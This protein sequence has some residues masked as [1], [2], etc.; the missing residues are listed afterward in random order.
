VDFRPEIRDLGLWVKNQG[1]RPSCAI[2]ALLSALEYQAAK[3]DGTARRFDED[4][5]LRQVEE[6]TGRRALHGATGEDA[7]YNLVEVVDTIRKHGLRALGE[8][9]SSS[10]TEPAESFPFK[11]DFGVI[12]ATRTHQEI[13]LLVE[14]INRGF[15]LPIALSWP[16]PAATQGGLIDTQDP[17]PNYRHAVTLVGYENPTGKIEDTVF[18]FKNSWGVHWGASGFGRVSYRYFVENFAYAIIIQLSPSRQE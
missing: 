1:T 4:I 16:Y 7:G 11:I 5:L 9:S 6:V 13:H 17:Q 3:L 8:T 18:L 15:P 12:P 14:A 2:F 10:E